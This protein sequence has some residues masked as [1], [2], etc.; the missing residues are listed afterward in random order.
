MAYI[1]FL[2]GKHLYTLLFSINLTQVPIDV[3]VEFSSL[4]KTLP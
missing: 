3:D 4:L 1:E 2:L